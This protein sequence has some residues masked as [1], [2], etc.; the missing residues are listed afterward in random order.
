MLQHFDD[1]SREWKEEKPD[2]L[3]RALL[4]AVTQSPE[5]QERLAELLVER[6]ARIQYQPS[7]SL[8]KLPLEAA[9]TRGLL[10]VV[11]YLLRIKDI[12]GCYADTLAESGIRTCSPNIKLLFLPMGDLELG[13]DLGSVNG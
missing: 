11:N 5:N 10:D 7:E 9:V 3:T 13:I 1:R 4:T 12:E 8:P 6:G 2:I